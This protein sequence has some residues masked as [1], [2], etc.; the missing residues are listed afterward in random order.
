MDP[1]EPSTNADKLSDKTLQEWREY[2]DS[3]KALE[4]ELVS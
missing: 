2:M 4:R 1:L 3:L